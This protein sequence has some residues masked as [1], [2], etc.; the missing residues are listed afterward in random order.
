MKVKSIAILLIAAC[1]MSSFSAGASSTVTQNTFLSDDVKNTI[2]GFFAT[3]SAGYNIYDGNGNDVTWFFYE[4]NLDAYA[5]ENYEHIAANLMKINATIAEPI[6]AQNVV[7]QWTSSEQQRTVS[8][9]YTTLTE[10]PGASSTGKT[11][12]IND[13]KYQIAGTYTYNTDIQG[14]TSSS[15]TFVL[16][17]SPWDRAGYAVLSNVGAIEG[18]VEVTFNQCLYLSTSSH[19]SSNAKSVS[20]RAGF[21]AVF[22][23]GISY[24]QIN[25]PIDQTFLVNV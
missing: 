5:A 19:I 16:Q 13:F 14:I 15:A 20:F 11:V 3:G 9:Q 4:S 8:R 17:S 6:V 22:L 7:Q 12:Y 21:T 18:T 25:L 1:L 10:I 23:E 24:H 2:D